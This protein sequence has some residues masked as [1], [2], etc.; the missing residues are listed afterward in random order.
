MP[1]PLSMSWIAPA[2]GKG[3]NVI[4][5]TSAH[6]NEFAAICCSMCRH[7]RDIRH[8]PHN[9]TA[10]VTSRQNLDV[11]NFI[12]DRFFRTRSQRAEPAAL[13]NNMREQAMQDDGRTLGFSSRPDHLRI[14]EHNRTDIERRTS[15]SRRSGYD[16]F[17]A[18]TLDLGDDGSRLLRHRLCGLSTPRQVPPGLNAV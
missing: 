3:G 15:A 11:P 10:I 16:P 7:R 2:R 14:A 13:F 8:V 5:C 1:F 18:R 17:R 4:Q 12:D 6:R 9:G